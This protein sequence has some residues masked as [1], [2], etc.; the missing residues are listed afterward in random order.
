MEDDSEQA[1][2]LEPR[3]GVREC[4]QS[5]ERQVGYDD[6]KPMGSSS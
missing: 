4:E 3:A 6:S 2:F 5:G 1:G